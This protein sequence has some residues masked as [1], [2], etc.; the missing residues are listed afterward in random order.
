MVANITVNLA[1]QLLAALVA[2]AAVLYGTVPHVDHL[3]KLQASAVE[4]LLMRV[5]QQVQVV[6]A[7]AP[8]VLTQVVE[9]VAQI[10][11]T[12]PTVTAV[13]A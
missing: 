6:T 12:L 13:Q 10:I 3:V 8:E 5:N 11:E 1:K 4:W 2:A 7:A 9:A